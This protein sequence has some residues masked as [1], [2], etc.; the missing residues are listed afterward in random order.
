[1]KKGFPKKKYWTVEELNLGDTNSPL[2]SMISP[3]FKAAS[4]P[5][6]S[7]M[8]RKV[9]CATRADSVVRPAG[10]WLVVQKSLYSVEIGARWAPTS[11][12]MGL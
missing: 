12:R 3:T 7:P 11:Y 8:R 1:M 10:R 4:V 2:I 9:L 5:S 6:S